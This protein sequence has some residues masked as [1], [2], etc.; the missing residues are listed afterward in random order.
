MAD[1]RDCIVV[2]IDLQGTKNLAQKGNS[3]ATGIMRA[4]HRKVVD[5][6][7]K[8]YLS[9]I[10]QVYLWNDSALLLGYVDTHVQAYEQIIRAADSL[11]R[12]V[13]E[14]SM[15]YAVSV[16]GQ[17]FPRIG[18]QPSG[19]TVIEASSYALGNCM[20][21][22]NVAKSKKLTC[23]WY[24]DERIAKKVSATE[25][26]TSFGVRMLPDNQERTVYGHD[27]YLWANS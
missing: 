21:V 6:R 10:E 17:A 15:S 19:T 25:S 13:D 5:E 2:Y 22:E 20:T 9:S 3:E 1:W 27:G 23:S 8:S 7:P 24:V 12:E 14:I 26:K 16:K 4:F 11:K 18:A